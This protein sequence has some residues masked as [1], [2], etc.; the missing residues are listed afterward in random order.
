MRILLLPVLVAALTVFRVHAAEPDTAKTIT[1]PDSLIVDGIP[2][3]PA[4][5][6]DQVGRYT[7]A[8]AAA[9]HR[10]ASGRAESIILTRFADTNQVHIVTQPGGARSS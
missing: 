10:L 1:P 5:M 7:E 4:N 6:V 8:R 9:F 2:P 3:I